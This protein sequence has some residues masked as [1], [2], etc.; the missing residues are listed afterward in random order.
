MGTRKGA[1]VLTADGA[2]RRWEVAGP[3]FP[4]REVFHVKGSPAAPNRV[5]AAQHAQ[6]TDWFGQVVQG[7]RDGGRTWNAVGN[8]FDYE[9]ETLRSA[10]PPPFS[11]R[12]S[13]CRLLNCLTTVTLRGVPESHRLRYPKGETTWRR[14]TKNP[15]AV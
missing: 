3:H 6:H 11:I 4:G 12:S 13:I 5:Y 15:G 2:R 8:E 1:F 7:S 10:T 14:R 9:G